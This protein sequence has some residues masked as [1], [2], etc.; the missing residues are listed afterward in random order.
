MFSQKHNLCFSYLSLQ[1]MATLWLL[2]EKWQEPKSTFQWEVS[3]R[4]RITTLLSSRPDRQITDSVKWMVL[5]L[6]EVFNIFLE[7][8]VCHLLNS[9]FFVTSYV[10]GCVTSAHLGTGS[11]DTMCGSVIYCSCINHH[12][13]K[14]AVSFWEHF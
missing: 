10:K 8:S 12:Q 3:E 2:T 4:H 5:L 11:Q 7:I 13:E 6:T 9:V 14:N 1:T